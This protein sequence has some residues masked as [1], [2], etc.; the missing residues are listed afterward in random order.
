MLSIVTNHSGGVIIV[1]VSNVV[2]K[3][4]NDQIL[5]Q[6]AINKDIISYNLLAKYLRPAIEK[7]LGKGVKHS[8]VVMSLRRYRDKLE[9][10]KKQPVFNYFKET[11]LKTDICYLVLE[12]DPN[13][14]KKV[15]NIYPQI[16]VKR[17]GIFN[18]IQGN[19]EMGI[20]TNSRYKKKIVELIG[21]EKILQIIEDLVVV[22][23]TYSKDFLFT[24]GIMYNVLR[25][26]AWENI[27]IVT[28]ILTPKELNLVIKR[29]DTV[30]CYETLEKMVKTPQ[31]PE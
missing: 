24:P 7:E 13:S 30:K 11:I 12:E 1:T 4:V 5:L 19:Y 3:L 20:I 29:E 23:L 31:Q 25:F 21:E 10:K 14:L 9:E 26:I 17:G 27:N 28:I 16:D 22:S 6:E 18:I 15:L 2:K 8:A